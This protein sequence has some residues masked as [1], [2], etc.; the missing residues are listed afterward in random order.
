MFL[1][2]SYQRLILNCE[3][4]K[5]FEILLVLNFNRRNSNLNFDVLDLNFGIAEK[6][7]FEKTFSKV[8]E[9]L[10]KLEKTMNR[11]LVIFI[12]FNQIIFTS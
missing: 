5:I 8:Y 7:Y 6:R 9:I 3:K 1:Q 4:R 12:Y 2:K 11:A 10:K